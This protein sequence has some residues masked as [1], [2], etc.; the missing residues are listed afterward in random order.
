[1]VLLGKPNHQERN[2]APNNAQTALVNYSQ[3]QYLPGKQEV[4]NPKAEPRMVFTSSL[5]RL[6]IKYGGKGVLWSNTFVLDWMKQP[7]EW[8]ELGH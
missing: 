3:A 2:G 1:M 7:S 8:R 5:F 6:F 4:D